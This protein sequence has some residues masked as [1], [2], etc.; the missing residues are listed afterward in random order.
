MGGFALADLF[1]NFGVRG[2]ESLGAGI[3]DVHG[4]LT[5]F[6]G[7]INRM[8]PAFQGFGTAVS[9]NLRN[10]FRELDRL[11]IPLA[12]LG[13]SM[14]P[15][16][17]GAARAYFG[18]TTA[19]VSLTAAAISA[20]N[21]TAFMGFASQAAG[22]S[23][24]G[25]LQAMVSL[26]T[27]ADRAALSVEI[28]GRVAAAA[29]SARAVRGVSQFFGGLRQAV[30]GVAGLGPAVVTLGRSIVMGLGGI[31]MAA[32]SSGNRMQGLRVAGQGGLGGLLAM[33]QSVRPLAGVL[34]GVGRSLLG[35]ANTARG[36]IGPVVSAGAAITRAFGTVLLGAL[37]ATA[38]GVRSLAGAVIADVRRMTTGVAGL[39]NR[40]GSSVSGAMSRAMNLRNMIYGSMAAGGA[41]W[42]VGGALKLESNRETYTTAFTTMLEGDVAK[43][44]RLMAGLSD[45]AAHT[46]FRLDQAR[47][48]ARTLLSFGFAAAS[49]VPSLRMIGNVASGSKQPL[50]DIARIYGEVAQKGRLMG[51]DLRQFNQRGI[52]VVEHLSRTLGVSKM[53]IYKMAENGQLGFSKLEAAFK[54]MTG[55]GGVFFEMME[56]QSL[57]LEGRF[58][59]LQDEA[60]LLGERLG[61]AMAPAAKGVIEKLI[62]VTER[63]NESFAYIRMYVGDAAS[64]IG[65]KLV[66]GVDMAIDAFAAWWPVIQQ[67]GRTVGAM[68]SVAWDGLKAVGG[69]IYAAVKWLFD[70]GGGFMN[71]ME[72]MEF[73]FTNYQLFSQLAGEYTALF[74]QNSTERFRTFF[75]NLGRLALWFATSWKDIFFNVSD[76]ILTIMINLGQNIRNLFD[77]VWNYIQ[78]GRFNFKEINLMA[79]TEAA[80]DRIKASVPQLAAAATRETNEGIQAIFR[81]MGQAEA[82]FQRKKAERQ[83]RKPALEED[84]KSLEDSDQSGLEGAEGTARRRGRGADRFGVH[85]L[86]DFAKFLQAGID[87]E[88]RKQTEVQKQMA[89][90]IRH[91]R[92]HGIA[93][94]IP[95][96]AARFADVA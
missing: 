12:Q 85:S 28:L 38:N 96:Q 88:K 72:N 16:A 68:L 91:I 22:I 86:E 87:P 34:A 84:I 43:A 53:E 4:L 33:L 37:R 66:A 25:L 50:Q 7:T 26:P 94:N 67:T 41:G 65:E 17:T 51:D 23:V 31:G 44:K 95:R 24:R 40:M 1:V 48:G 47:Q 42:A 80:I 36:V 46:P 20:S 8:L 89:G 55:K 3:G 76:V 82:E 39:I 60:M 5:N 21:R 19:L 29:F 2:L 58:S 27:V 90:D 62:G 56:K 13:Q 35:V 71:V 32:L 63:V 30:G 64:W 10:I 9:R 18:L 69:A 15:V 11:P 81:Q 45:F 70:L 52:P 73:F 83:N 6:T 75:D 77:A 78:G 92:E 57:T 54:S 59:T 74:I 79:G 61:S 49:V 93:V 14:I